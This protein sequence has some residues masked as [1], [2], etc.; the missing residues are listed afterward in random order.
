MRGFERRRADCKS[1][2]V[3]LIFL[4]RG[5]HGMGRI[6][7]PPGIRT[8]TACKGMFA[9]SFLGCTYIYATVLN[10]QLER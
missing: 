3:S 5:P 8:C 1:V 10:R 4:L 9:V 2:S 7:T 6:E